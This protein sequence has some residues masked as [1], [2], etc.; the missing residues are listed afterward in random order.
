MKVRLNAPLAAFI[1]LTLSACGGAGSSAVNGGAMMPST[2][3]ANPVGIDGVEP[4]TKHVT[5]IAALGRKRLAHVVVA[6]YKSS[7]P[8]CP[9]CQ[10]K[11]NT[12]V[13]E[14]VTN[15]NGQVVLSGSWTYKNFMC[16]VGNSTSSRHRRIAQLCAQPLPKT[17]KLQFK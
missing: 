11:R 12:Q 9:F 7:R 15:S 2:N 10:P 16:V 4:L 14:G 3:A 5:I 1:V 17:L 13:A 8:Q 6:L